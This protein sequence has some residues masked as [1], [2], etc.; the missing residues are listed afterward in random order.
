MPA[1]MRLTNAYNQSSKKGF[2]WSLIGLLL[3]AAFL[4]FKPATPAQQATEQLVLSADS[5]RVELGSYM[6]YTAESADS[7]SLE[8]LDQA[9]V[10]WQ[11][12]HV[13][14]VSLGYQSS[15]YWFRTEWQTAA[16]IPGNW[17]LEISNSHLDSLQLYLTEDGEPV[18]QWQTGDAQPY[19]QRPMDHP[20][21]L[22]PLQLKPR[23]QYQL[24]IHITNTE[25]MELP[26][27]IMTVP[28]YTDFNSIRAWVDGIFNGFLIIMAAYSIALFATLWDRSYLFYVSYIIAMLLF[29][30]YQQGLLYKFVFPHW[31]KVQHYAPALISLYIFGSIALFFRQ[32]LELPQ[33]LPKHWLCYKVMLALHAI[34]CLLFLVLPYQ[35]AMYL[36][37]INTILSTLLAVLSIIKLTLRG[38]VSAQIVLAGWTLLLFFLIIFTAAK[39][40]FI[41]NE[42]M[43]VY[44]LRIG[45]SVEILIFSFALSYR[46]NQERQDKELALEQ[47]NQERNAK[48]QAQ[49]LALQREIEANTAKEEALRLEI[50]HREE[51]QELV[52]ERTADLERT[53]QELAKSNQELALLSSKDGLTG[54]N[55]RRVFDSKL[56]EYW[57]LALRNGKPMSLL[58]IDIDHFKQINDSRG[59]QCGDQ[60]LQQFAELLQRSLQRP[61]DFIARYGGEEFA[62]LLADTPAPGAETIAD[63]IV[64]QAAQAHF[65]WQGDEFQISVSVGVATQRLEQ[66]ATPEELVGNADAALYQAKHRGRNRWIAYQDGL[67]NP[68][69]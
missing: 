30:L 34:Y 24:T 69:H 64:R 59:H 11:R 40:G 37:V 18:A 65:S 43:A 2:I 48:M 39:T 54:L 63:K 42:F 66:D 45:I 10:Q 31:P 50:K 29:F 67:A 6:R 16:D 12:N 47:A 38:S 27:R 62:V 23:H 53:L 14:A 41:Y 26:I 3:L 32:L 17:L 1:D 22:F 36:L 51:L 61:G 7:H 49:E 28:A 56:Q 15:P 57:S 58:I 13:D 9:A 20:M 19:A 44:G 60:V 35:T 33:Q 55:N 52:E 25:A 21:F 46:I 5:D 8:Q 68:L 4:I